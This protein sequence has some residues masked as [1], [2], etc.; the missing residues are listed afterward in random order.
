M[1]DKTVQNSQKGVC[2]LFLTSVIY[3]ILSSC[4]MNPGGGGSSGSTGN[5][6]GDSGIQKSFIAIPNTYKYGLPY[7][8]SRMNNTQLLA[9]YNDWKAHY[10]VSTGCPGGALRVQRDSSTGNDTVSESMSYGLLLA[11]YFNDQTTFNGLYN[12]VLAH[13]NGQGLM[14]WRI[15]QYGNNIDE[16][17]YNIPAGTQHGYLFTNGSGVQTN[18]DG[19]VVQ[20]SIL[21]QAAA[22]PVPAGYGLYENPRGRTS[23]TDADEDIA[24]ALCMAIKVWGSAYQAATLMMVNNLTNDMMPG[25]LHGDKQVFLGAGD[26]DNGP[27]AFGTWGGYTAEG[28]KAGWDPSYYTPQ[29]YP[30]FKFVSGNAIWDQ[31]TNIMWQQCAIV[32]Q[33]NNGTGLFPDWCDTSANICQQTVLAS[34][35]GPQDFA[36]Y[37]DAVRVPWRMSIAY[38]WYSDPAAFNIAYQNATFFES[39]FY[40]GNIKDGYTITGIPVNTLS[41]AQQQAVY[42]A[43]SVPNFDSTPMAQDAVFLSMIGSS[44]LPFAQ[45]SGNLD[46]ANR[47]YIAITN[48]KVP[49]TNPYGH[50]FGNTL[51]LLA[52]L[53]LNGEF[54]NYYDTNNYKTATV[55]PIPGTVN[56]EDYVN[57]GNINY[58][59]NL[60]GI[61]A[62]CQGTG[63]TLSYMVSN[64]YAASQY[65]L[66]QIVYT[67][68]CYP[69][70]SSPGFSYDP[71]WVT[72]TVDSLL[73]AES[74][75][76]GVLNAWA[77][78]TN[79]VLMTPGVHNITLGICPNP[80][81]FSANFGIG[82]M[83]FTY[84]G[85][86]SIVSA[87]GML[88]LTNY[89]Y[90]NNASTT[91]NTMSFGLYNRSGQFAA[92]VLNVPGIPGVT[93]AKNYTVSFYGLGVTYHGAT[94]TSWY[95]M[96]TSTSTF[97]DYSYSGSGTPPFVSGTIS[98]NPGLQVLVISSGAQMIS[99]VS[100]K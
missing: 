67:V 96:S 13:T 16:V 39:L 51:R 70:S 59:T 35:K 56:I 60:G 28:N 76:N 3:L 55:N 54:V 1:T 63:K 10:V 36:F 61:A 48:S 5:N 23:A 9:E 42:G 88:N 77:T 90:I 30:I 26:Y 71:Q 8:P 37:Y 17:G 44:V 46:Y 86:P 4:T 38:S 49:Y 74:H 18:A 53:Y 15:D 14:H 64:T 34:D 47:F 92:Y 58:L 100:I 80:G 66:Y 50:Y 29:W 85:V 40:A 83:Q 19:T 57:T 91:T 33:A 98:L 7:I 2:L 27:G 81:W 93:P 24:G 69:V 31:L 25:W 41:S 21:A 95:N 78:V 22:T 89:A 32:G 12:Y 72:L 65:G 45:P 75:G 62:A 87:T 79:I 73:Q 97:I 84:L 94:F 20:S 52:L 6:N 99:N 82:S 11:V 43:G 68:Y